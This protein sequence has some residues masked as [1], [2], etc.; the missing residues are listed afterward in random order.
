MGKPESKNADDPHD[1]N[2]SPTTGYGS[3]GLGPGGQI[4]PY[5]ILRVLGEGGC[6][7]VYLAE[8]QEPIRRRVALKVIKPG[9]DTKQV[10]API[11]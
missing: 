4:G 9:M 1:N 10:N 8:Q 2:P 6:G 3:Q 5:K 11:S 7:M